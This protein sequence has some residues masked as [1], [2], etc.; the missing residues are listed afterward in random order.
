VKTLLANRT[1]FSIDEVARIARA[2][3]Q[4]NTR[5]KLVVSILNTIEENLGPLLQSFL[6]TVGKLS[7]L[8]GAP[9]YALLALKCRQLLNHH[10]LP[11][12]SERRIAILTLLETASVTTSE[13]R[14]S[15]LQSITNHAHNIEDMVFSFLTPNSSPGIKTIS[16]EAY[17]HRVYKAYLIKNT[18]AGFDRKTDAYTCTWEFHLQQHEAVAESG[19][20][21]LALK[22]ASALRGSVSIADLVNF[23]QQADTKSEAKSLPFTRQGLLAYFTDLNLLKTNLVSV[24]N[25]RTA[26]WQT[27]T[28]EPVNVLYLLVSWRQYLPKNDSQLCQT[29]QQIVTTHTELFRQKGLR[30]VTFVIGTG[31]N[32]PPLYFTFRQQSDTFSEDCGLRHI[33]PSNAVHMQLHRLSQYT[34]RSIPTS[35]RSV[36][37]FEGIPNSYPQNRRDPYDGRCLWGRVL[38]QK[39]SSTDQGE[40]SGGHAYPEIEFTFVKALSALEL[41]IAGQSKK[42]RYNHIFINVL[43]NNTSLQPSTVESLIR[44][45]ARRYADKVR[46]LNLAELEIAIPLTVGSEAKKTENL[47]LHLFYPYS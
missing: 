33:E 35:N 4:L 26:A 21:A 3:R 31:T 36:H 27:T 17:V 1:Q 32:E 5:S 10:N 43:A 39:L 15:Q 45:I 25:T 18:S 6:P 38:L 12:F 41:A 2:H 24:V 14:F 42:W 29:F 23:G 8:V 19:T 7:L 28:S 40:D 20:G 37:L 30:R 11:S 34:L 44:A 46:R 22:A 13:L 9:E 16:L 47:S